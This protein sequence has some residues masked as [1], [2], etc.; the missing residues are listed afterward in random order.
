MG[1]SSGRFRDV[2][3][4]SGFPLTCFGSQIGAAPPSYKHFTLKFSFY[5]KAFHYLTTKIKYIW[6]KYIYI[7]EI[8]ITSSSG[9][10]EL[11]Y[12][13]HN[14]CYLRVLIIGS[15]VFIYNLK[16]RKGLVRV[17]DSTCMN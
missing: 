16:I 3:L 6:G 7:Q 8:Q 4:P 12:M 1:T 13:Y 14:E 15:V 10:Y 2:I 17:F 11:N 9:L 5:E